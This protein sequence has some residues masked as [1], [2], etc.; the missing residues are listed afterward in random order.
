MQQTVFQSRLETTTQNHIPVNGLRSRNSVTIIFVRRYL[1]RQYCLTHP[2]WGQLSMETDWTKNDLSR[3]VNRLFPHVS[4]IW[5][6]VFNMWGWWYRVWLSIRRETCQCGHV[7]ILHKISELERGIWLESTEHWPCL[8][9]KLSGDVIHHYDD[10]VIL[11]APGREPDDA[12]KARDRNKI[13]RIPTGWVKPRLRVC[14][15]TV[16]T[17]R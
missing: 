7:L 3:L 17:S 9:L 2:Y 12:M 13:L 5:H 16:T 4:L 11:V 6:F 15:F 8:C 14:C 1:N 10:G